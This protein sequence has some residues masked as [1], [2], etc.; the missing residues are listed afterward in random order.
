MALPT[1]Y[2]TS[3]KNLEAMLNSIQGAKAPVKFTQTFLES[4]GFQ[5]KTD[6]LIVAVLKAL[7]FLGEGGE[8]TQ[9]YFEFLDQTQGRRVLG[10][11]IENAYSDLFQINKHAHRLSAGEVKNKLRTLTQ[12]QPSDA[13]L[14]DMANTFVALAGQ[15]DFDTPRSP[16][17]PRKESVE[18]D[19]QQKYA[20][21]ESVGRRPLS[22]QGLQYV[23]N[24]QLPES[25]DQAVY[26]ALFRSMRE[27]LEGT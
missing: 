5:N 21:R 25:R 3:T 13:V 24:I 12:G 11:A 20:D 19:S 16:E 4:L 10:E 22:I 1:S 17:S 26:D 23:I 6:R 27:H 15:A 9:R 8:P 14:S 7:G 18:A 2:L